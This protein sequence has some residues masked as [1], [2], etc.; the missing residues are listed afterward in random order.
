MDLL[1]MPVI[2]DSALLSHQRTIFIDAD[3]RWVNVQ[4]GETVRFIAGDRTFTWNF[5]VSQSIAMFHLNHIAPPGMLTQEV[6]V[7]VPPDPVYASGG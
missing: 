4:G 5:Q 3:T 2:D 7:Y 6:A 1:G